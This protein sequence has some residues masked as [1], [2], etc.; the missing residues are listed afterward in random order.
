MA[1]VPTNQAD[2]I[3]SD[4]YLLRNLANYLY[5]QPIYNM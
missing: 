2:L 1:L 5:N 3:L 4:Y